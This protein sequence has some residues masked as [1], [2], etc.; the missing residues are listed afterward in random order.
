LITKRNNDETD[1]D[2]VFLEG[3]LE[4]NQPKR[5]SQ[6]RA[7]KRTNTNARAPKHANTS[8]PATKRANVSTMPEPQQDLAFE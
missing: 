4:R 3:A 6:Q 1:S 8:S 7:L 5:S 2:E